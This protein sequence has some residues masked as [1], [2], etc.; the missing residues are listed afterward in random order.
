LAAVFAGPAALAPIRFVIR[1]EA[2]IDME[3]K[4]W[5]VSAVKVLRAVWAAR[6]VV[7]K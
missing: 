3:K 1:V 4:N 5:K 2:A 7:E 6:W